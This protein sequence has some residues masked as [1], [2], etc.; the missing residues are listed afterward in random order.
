MF[1]RSSTIDAKAAMIDAGIAHVRDTVMPAMS[2]LD[3]F[4][5]LSLIVDRESGRCIATSAWRSEEAMHA[6][7]AR[8]DGLRADAAEAFGGDATVEEWEVALLHRAHHARRGSCMRVT[9]TTMD[10][11][12]LEGTLETFKDGTLAQIED[13]PG[14]CS[15]SLLV[16]RAAGRAVVTVGYD[17]RDA[18]ERSRDPGSSLR[19]QFARDAELEVLEVA[20]FDLELGHLHVPETV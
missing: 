10:P 15:A 12:R 4:V 5:G 17:D 19:G 8:A 9:W 2:H 11:E 16:N 7:A 1:A 3:G 20:E 14:F 18:L 13:L 6:S